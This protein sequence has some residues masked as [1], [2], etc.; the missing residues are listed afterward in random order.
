MQSMSLIIDKA[1]NMLIKIKLKTLN[2]VLKKIKIILKSH[3]L[4]TRKTISKCKAR[5][6]VHSTSIKMKAA[7]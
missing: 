7:F 5:E 4:R 2:K 1:T 6:K 3:Y